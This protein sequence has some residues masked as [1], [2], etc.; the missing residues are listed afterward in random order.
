MASLTARSINSIQR[1]ISLK[2]LYLTQQ[3]H[4]THQRKS[5]ETKLILI[6]FQWILIISSLRVESSKTK[7][8]HLW[9]LLSDNFWYNDFLCHRLAIIIWGLGAFYLSPYFSISLPLLSSP[10]HHSLPR[11]IFVFSSRKRVFF[12]NIASTTVMSVHENQWR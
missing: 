10:P 3:I 6:A 11:S 7:L 4:W 2:R 12:L 9:M 1:M 5:I 8:P